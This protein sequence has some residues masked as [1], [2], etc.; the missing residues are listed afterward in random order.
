M[1]PYLDFSENVRFPIKGGLLKGVEE[2][3]DTMQWL[4]ALRGRII[5]ALILFKLRV[6]GFETSDNNSCKNLTGK[7]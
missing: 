5:W 3:H 7:L 2:P 1:M 4:G 6:L